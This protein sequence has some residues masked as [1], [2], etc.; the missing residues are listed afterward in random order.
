MIEGKSKGEIKTDREEDDY[1]D[2]AMLFPSGRRNE[3]M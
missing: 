3:A 1:K 2:G